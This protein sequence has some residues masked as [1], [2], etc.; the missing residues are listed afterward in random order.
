MWQHISARK[1]SNRNMSKYHLGFQKMYRQVGRYPH[2]WTSLVNIFLYPLNITYTCTGMCSQLNMITSKNTGGLIWLF[3]PVI[4]NPS[5]H[6]TWSHFTHQITSHRRL[7]K[8]LLHNITKGGYYSGNIPDIS[9]RCYQIPDMFQ[10]RNQ[11][12]VKSK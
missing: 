4:L 3:T 6:S 1:W 2:H 9:T 10:F 7:C 11:Y 8:A 5:A 12:Q